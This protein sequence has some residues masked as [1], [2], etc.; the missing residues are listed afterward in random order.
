[1]LIPLGRLYDLNLVT[2]HSVKK[3]WFGKSFVIIFAGFLIFS[4]FRPTACAIHHEIKPLK[5][6]NYPR[7]IYI[8]LYLCV[9]L[10]AGEND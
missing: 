7:K 3:I 1:M 10:P 9:Q 5:L 2:I 8:H 6:N 4:R